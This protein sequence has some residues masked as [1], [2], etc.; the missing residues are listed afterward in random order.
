MFIHSKHKSGHTKFD[1]ERVGQLLSHPIG[2]EVVEFYMRTIDQGKTR[3]LTDI[4]LLDVYRF[5]Q[6]LEILRGKSFVSA[7]PPGDA[8]QQA[9]Y[10]YLTQLYLSMIS[11]T[12][13]ESQRGQRF[14]VRV[15]LR[16][17][18]GGHLRMKKG[19]TLL[20]RMKK[21]AISLLVC[22]KTLCSLVQASLSDG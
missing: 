10:D 7:T 13:F 15:T 8:H 2:V 20:L 19:T 12:S 3:L 9:I 18:F 5:A 22:S 16:I 21:G 1:R 17:K 4:A 6:L 14:P 11:G